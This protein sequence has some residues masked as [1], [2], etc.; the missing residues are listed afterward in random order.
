MSS[1]SLNLVVLILVLLSGLSDTG[2]VEFV[3]RADLRFFFKHVRTT[4][5]AKVFLPERTFMVPSRQRAI[6]LELQKALY[7]HGIIGR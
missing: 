2:E 7:A 6:P 4:P 1:A 3:R 5:A